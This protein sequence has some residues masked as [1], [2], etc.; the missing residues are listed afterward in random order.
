MIYLLKSILTIDLMR[1]YIFFLLAATYAV[2]QKAPAAK[3]TASTTLNP[4]ADDEEF[5][6]K[7]LPIGLVY[8]YPTGAKPAEI[9]PTG[10]K[11]SP[12]ANTT[13]RIKARKGGKRVAVR[14]DG[15]PLHTKYFV[16]PK[17]GTWTFEI[18]KGD[19]IERMIRVPKPKAAES[20]VI[21]KADAEEKKEFATDKTA[22]VETI[23]DTEQIAT[24]VQETEKLSDEF[25][26][27]F[28]EKMF[29]VSAG[30][31]NNF[32]EHF[33]QYF[34]LPSSAIL[35][36]ADVFFRQ[37]GGG[38]VYFDYLASGSGDDVPSGTTYKNANFWKLGYEGQYFGGWFKS[39]STPNPAGLML[40]DVLTSEWGIDAH[41]GFRI[42]DRGWLSLT[43]NLIFLW[44][45]K[46]TTVDTAL[47]ML[48]NVRAD[49]QFLAY[50]IRDFWD[51]YANTGTAFSFIDGTTAGY[52]TT[53]VWSNTP[54]STGTTTI[55]RHM[56]FAGFYLGASSY[57]YLLPGMRIALQADYYP[58][59][60][61]GYTRYTS[62]TR[63]T[64]T[65]MFIFSVKAEYRM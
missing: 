1:R 36:R 32:T 56:Q 31:T 23:K 4:T 62:L 50:R 57:L 6:Y 20:E 63:E 41:Y 60:S 2:A 42:T 12:T 48:I 34:T 26:R 22:E 55:S 16:K 35:L 18:E 17:K 13:L 54:A 8:N 19:V 9:F 53:G 3:G 14:V 15:N 61:T 7:W 47:S 44:Y 39:Q 49:F 29:G 58:V 59:M 45:D 5:E 25:I 11:F 51:L 28:H 24:Q 46:P 27:P 64:A 38:R 40:R 43:S 10:N 21:E 37:F 30:Y 65:S 33:A 52:S